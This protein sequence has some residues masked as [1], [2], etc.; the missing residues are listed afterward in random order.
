MNNLIDDPKFK[1]NP[2]K[3]DKWGVHTSKKENKK[4][5]GKGKTNETNDEKERDENEKG[6]GEEVEE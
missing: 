3:H 2:K 5:K 1:F 4:E 6:E